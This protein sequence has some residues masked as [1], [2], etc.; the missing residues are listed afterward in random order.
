MIAYSN[1][2]FSTLARSTARLTRHPMLARVRRFAASRPV[3][4]AVIV[5]A[6]CLLSNAAFADGLPGAGVN[7]GNFQS[8]P[9]RVFAVVSIILRTALIIGGGALGFKA[10]M[11]SHETGKAA[12]TYL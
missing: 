5:L 6:L 10:L 7:L 2:S 12:T 4:D 11:G 8:L 9:D 1:S 3:Q